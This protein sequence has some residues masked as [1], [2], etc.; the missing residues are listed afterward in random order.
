MKNSTQ[1]LLR[2]IRRGMLRT[3]LRLRAF[4]GIG[5]NDGARARVYWDDGVTLTV[6]NL[7]K[8]TE[9]NASGRVQVI[10]LA[11][12]RES[13][14]ELWGKYKG[15]ILIIAESTISR[16]IGKGNTFIPQEED[17]WLLLFPEMS[18][19]AAQQRADAIARAIGEKLMGAQFTAQE[20]PF[21][22]AS[23]LDL[24]GALNVDGS[25]NMDAVKIAVSKIR[26]KQISSVV[27]SK[28]PAP[29]KAG[30][31]TRARATAPPSPDRTAVQSAQ[32]FFR[33]A[34]SSDTECVDSFFFRA[35]NDAGEDLYSETVPGDDATFLNLA[36]IAA[37]AFSAMCSSGLQ[38]KLTIPV[39]FITLRGPGLA[40]IERLITGLRQRDRLLRLRLE[41]VRI[42][43]QATADMLLSI[44][45]IF[46][47]HVRDVTF[48]QD[49]QALNSQIL[50]L[51]HIMIGTEIGSSLPISDEDVFQTMLLFR[52]RAGRRPTYILGLKNRTHF[53]HAVRA[54]IHEVGSPAFFKDIKALPQRTS[55]IS[56]ETL[57][58]P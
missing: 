49:F 35:S 22:A 56:R 23:K 48:V 2:K 36:K 40:E 20:L 21:P 58:T 1:R 14:G 19:D 8:E 42:P 53:L 9:T 15:R 7:V 44:R 33:P 13:I 6:S 29:S 30:G 27:Q 3:A 38:A 47:P 37:G 51:D 16:M 50:A 54:G 34:W 31:M 52:Q 26:Q 46:R 39:P 41:V 25:L 12:F 43:P 18:E 55:V 45:E 32:V 5:K 10:S 57:L 24:S 17:A 11:D 28:T 4:L